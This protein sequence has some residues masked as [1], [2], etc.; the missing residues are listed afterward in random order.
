MC[1]GSK[2]YQLLSC[3]SCTSVH[4]FSHLLSY[5]DEVA[6]AHRLGTVDT[7]KGRLCGGRNSKVFVFALLSALCFLG[8]WGILAVALRGCQPCAL[9]RISIQHE[10]PG[11]I[12]NIPFLYNSFILL[13]FQHTSFLCLLRYSIIHICFF[14]SALSILFSNQELPLYNML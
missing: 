3:L 9:K 10:I 6:S 2:F 8:S 11:I 14:V 7:S 12:N 4:L 5:L 1:F 13:A